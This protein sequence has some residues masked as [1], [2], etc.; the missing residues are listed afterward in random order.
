MAEIEFDYVKGQET[1]NVEQ[2][3]KPVLSSVV[4]LAKEREESI[5][6][7]NCSDWSCHIPFVSIGNLSEQ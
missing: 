4:C 1:D 6:R 5:Q 3:V 2:I 7:C